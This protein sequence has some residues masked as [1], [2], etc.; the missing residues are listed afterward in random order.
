MVEG[1]LNHTECYYLSLKINTFC[2]FN[3]PFRLAIGSVL[4]E[5]DIYQVCNTALLKGFCQF[6]IICP[7]K[8]RSDN[9]Y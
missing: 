9:T 1:G 5:L 6:L 8:H 4:K 7:L 2:H 3:S